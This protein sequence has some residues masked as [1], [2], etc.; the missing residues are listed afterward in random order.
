MVIKVKHL[1]I[2]LIIKIRK[3]LLVY[4]KLNAQEKTGTTT[5]VLTKHFYHNV[6]RS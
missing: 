5:T 1:K 3:L 2:I 4:K 6:K